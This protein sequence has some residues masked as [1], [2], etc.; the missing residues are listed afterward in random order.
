[1][2]TGF[3]VSMDMLLK[4]LHCCKY[5]YSLP[6]ICF[7]YS[8]FVFHIVLCF[9]V[10]EIFFLVL[11][12]CVILDILLDLLQVLR[13]ELLLGPWLTCSVVDVSV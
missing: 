9:H 8:N 5:F 12:I 10:Y 1:M 2:S 6:V 7:I 3:T 4:R 11:C 13:L